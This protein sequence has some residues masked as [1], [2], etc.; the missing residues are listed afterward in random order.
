MSA[1]SFSYFFLLQ[2]ECNLMDILNIDTEKRI[3]T[4]E[5]MVSIRRLCEALIPLGWTVPIV[6]EIGKVSII[7]SRHCFENKLLHN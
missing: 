1:V 5:P 3:V 6:P 4:V 7:S 2:V